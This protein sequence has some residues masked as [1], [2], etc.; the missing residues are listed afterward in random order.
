MSFHRCSILL[1]DGDVMAQ[2]VP[3]SLQEPAQGDDAMWYGT[4]TITHQVVLQAGQRYHL[5]LDDGRRG[6]FLVRRN[7][8]AGDVNRAVAIHGMEPLG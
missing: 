6:V 5:V 8:F 2:D 7:T 4:L 3:V 1:E